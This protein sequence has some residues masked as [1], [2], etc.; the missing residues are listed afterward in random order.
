MAVRLAAAGA[1][2]LAG[3]GRYGDFTLPALP[4]T[5]DVRWQWAAAPDPVLR[6]SS[7]E[8][9]DVLNPSVIEWHSRLWN[10]YS[11]FDGTAWHTALAVS[12]DG[13]VWEK[14]G[15]ALTPG[16][17]TWEGGYIAANGAA[18]AHGGEI[19]YWYQAGPKGGTRIGLAR[20]KD[21]V[22]WRKGA[23][24]VMDPGPRGS[25]DE[26]AL[27]DPY[28]FEAGNALY[29]F[30]L[31]EDRARRQRL[32][33]ARSRDGVHWKKL[34]SNPVLQLGEYGAFDE[35]GLGEPAV[36]ASDGWYWMLYTGRDRTER[37]RMGMARSR[38]GV[39]W[40]RTPLVISGNQDW[41]RAVVCDA[42]VLADGDRVRV[43]FGGGDRPSPDENLNG[44]IGLGYLRATLA[45]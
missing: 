31:G 27:G 10:L 40:Q 24:P 7:G 15:I 3:C 22:S 13:V 20:S 45:R 32:G 43:W 9:R 18:L 25:W 28:V 19:L 35:A 44:A 34:R 21:G 26:I 37:R 29:L 12:D 5:T 6:P 17:S 39:H 4:G 23:R 42:T 1:L 33:L 2:L 36:W 11:G 41:N 8:T 16:A 30:Y 14:R 38:D